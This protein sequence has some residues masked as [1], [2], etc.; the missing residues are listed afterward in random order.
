MQYGPVDKAMYYDALPTRSYCGLYHFPS[1]RPAKPWYAFKAFN[2]LYRLGACAPAAS[3]DKTLYPI[4]ASG[5]EEKAIL[6]SAFGCSEKTVAVDMTGLGGEAVQAEVYR[7]DE[8]NDLA[9]SKVEY[10]TA[11]HVR[12]L[13]SVEDNTVFLIR[14][15]GMEPN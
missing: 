2:E 8:Q 3:D 14:I 9:L 5:G 12:L 4:A 6:L 1:Q 11:D 13:L 15:R 10:F 7:L